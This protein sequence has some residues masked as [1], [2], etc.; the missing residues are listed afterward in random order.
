MSQY[1]TE[2]IL[3]DEIAQVGTEAH[4]R[5]CTLVVSPFLHR[6]AFEENEA[7]AVEDLLAHGLE[8]VCHVW[9]GELG[10]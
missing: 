6:E 3:G 5:H 9:E 4:I 1:V 8:E 2:T 10:L 7:F